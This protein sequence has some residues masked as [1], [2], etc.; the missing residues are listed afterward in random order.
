[1]RLVQTLTSADGSSGEGRPE[2]CAQSSIGAE[3]REPSE[4]P[5]PLILSGEYEEL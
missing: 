5:H 1:M 2:Q 4:S 3:D